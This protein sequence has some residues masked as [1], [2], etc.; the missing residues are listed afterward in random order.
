MSH[1]RKESNVWIWSPEMSLMTF[2]NANII[3]DSHSKFA[4][5]LYVKFTTEEMIPTESIV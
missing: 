5:W 3:K 1:T 4:N 2:K